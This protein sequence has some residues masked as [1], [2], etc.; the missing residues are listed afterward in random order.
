MTKIF[1]AGGAL[2]AAGASILLIEFLRFIVVAIG[3]EV[4]I[5]MERRDSNFKNNRTYP[6][7]KTTKES[8]HEAAALNREGCFFGKK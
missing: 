7:Y 3:R 4:S 1:F 8:E 5:R 2:A 6:C